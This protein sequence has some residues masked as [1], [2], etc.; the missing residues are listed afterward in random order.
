MGTLH[1]LWVTGPACI[2]SW[3]WRCVWKLEALKLEGEDQPIDSFVLHLH[4][5]TAAL[6]LRVMQSAQS[7]S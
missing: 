3:D 2:S 1:V 5:C 6:R 4:M 7:R